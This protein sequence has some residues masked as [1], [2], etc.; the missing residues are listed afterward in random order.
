VTVNPSLFLPT[1]ETTRQE[2]GQAKLHEQK[3]RHGERVGE[4]MLRLKTRELVSARRDLRRVFAVI[5]LGLVQAIR[6]ERE[7]R[8]PDAEDRHGKTD[9]KRLAQQKEAD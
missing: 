9:W 3:E 5:E 7:D 2:N 4:P 8:G 6:E 1:D